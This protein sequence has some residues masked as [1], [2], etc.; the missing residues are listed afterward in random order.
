[1]LAGT[2]LGKGEYGGLSE[3]IRCYNQ[4][5][6]DSQYGHKPILVPSVNALSE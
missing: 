6:E 3:K 2:Y 5:D 4:E 1:M